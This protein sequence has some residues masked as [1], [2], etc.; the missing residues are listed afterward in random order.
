MTEYELYEASVQR[1]WKERERYIDTMPSLVKAL[2]QSAQALEDI[3]EDLQY[4]VSMD[5]PALLNGR[6]TL[7]ATRQTIESAKKSLGGKP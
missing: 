5:N 2:E 6:R 3:V 1:L 7:E 4:K